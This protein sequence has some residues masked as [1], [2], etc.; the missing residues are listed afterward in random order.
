VIDFPPAAPETHRRKRRSLYIQPPRRRR[1][2]RLV[3]LPLVSV[4]VLI[5]MGAAFT[6]SGLIGPPSVA[7]SFPADSLVYDRAGNLIADIHPP[8]ET[9]IPVP[10]SA[11]S[12]DVQRAIVAI[13]DRNFWHEGATDW[14]RLAQVAVYD[15]THRDE[16]QGASTITAQLAR[17]LYLNNEK[18]FERK[19]RE[20]AIAQTM[21]ARQSKTE[22]LN[23][24]LNDVYFGH[25][26]TGIEAASRVYFGVPA[27]E[28]DL[29]QASLLAGLPNAP[30]RLD[31]LQH[32][33]AARARQ[34]LVLDAM[35]RSG[36]VSAAEADSAYQEKLKF[37]SGEANNVNLYAQLTSRVVQSVSSQLG[38]DLS[39]AGLTVK[40]TVDPRLQQAAQKAVQSRVNAL[41]GLHVSNGAVVSLDPQT[42]DVLAYVGSAGPGHPGSNLDMASKPR[43][44]GSTMK[45]ATYSAAIAGRKVTMLTPVS[46][47]PLTLPRGG[48]ADGKQP[49]TVHDYDNG[50]RGVVPVAVAL[51]NS[52]NIPAV[53]VQQEVGTA[54]VVQLAR[55]LGM[56][57]LSSPPSSYGP[58]LTLGTYPVPLWQLAQAYG[59]VATGGV[60]HPARFV[61][62]VTDVSGRELLPPL[63]SGSRVLDPGAAF[64]MNQI[65]SDD[66]NRALV[67]GGGSDLVVA[68]HTVAAKTGTTSDSRDALTVGWTPSLVTAAWVGNADNSPMDGVA[69]SMGAAPVW[70]S[71]MAAG[72]GSRSDGWPGPPA[73]VHSLY[74]NGRQGWFLDGTGPSRSPLGGTTG[75]GDAGCQGLSIFERLQRGCPLRLGGG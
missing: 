10:L 21:N 28:L 41:G 62:S 11:I 2:G 64:I 54:N 15:V 65:L 20:L 24:Y 67:F 74:S 26:A 71:V 42:G 1:I 55:H 6:R 58:S 3:A 17:L 7:R 68:G 18:T 33:D 43:Q 66:S 29:A 14:G 30:S 31:P 19:L 63:G 45:V 22:I 25:G 70:H 48:G 44:P 13:E 37:A 23:E 40:T 39:T 5:S 27:S 60:L 34:R 36:A 56:E 57:A 72:L 69:G 4:L 8:G 46:D 32:P 75:S 73:N 16:P 50:N 51:G 38:K 59:A 52:L 49:W 12:P 47:G 35:V 53:R 61:L 9:R